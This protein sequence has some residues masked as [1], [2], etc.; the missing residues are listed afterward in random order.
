VKGVEVP[1]GCPTSIPQRHTST[2]VKYQEVCYQYVDVEKFWDDARDYCWQNGGS[3][4]TIDDPDTNRFIVDTLNSLPWTN[5]GLWIGLHDRSSELDW[6]WVTAFKNDARASWYNWGSGHPGAFLHS[7]RDCVRMKRR[8]GWKWHETYCHFLK[9]HYRFICEYDADELAEVDPMAAVHV[10]MRENH[11]VTT[12]SPTP[13]TEGHSETS[14]RSG[15]RVEA[16]IQPQLRSSSNHRKDTHHNTGGTEEETQSEPVFG[17][18]ILV[19][20]VK[21][22]STRNFESQETSTPSSVS[23]KSLI[24]QKLLFNVCFFFINIRIAYNT[25][26]FSSTY[27]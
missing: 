18:K 15:G 17:E 12:P 27:S 21:S 1:E 19:Y 4:V 22:K 8:D 20:K 26:V 24:F 23:N 5:N 16:G 7:H 9:Y 3:L 11:A 14:V 13:S 10:G 25:D 2:I 6:T